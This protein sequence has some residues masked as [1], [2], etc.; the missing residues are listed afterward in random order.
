MSTWQEIRNKSC[1]EI[2]SD[3]ETIEVLYNHDHNGN[4]Y[5]EIPIEFV[6]SLVKERAIM[7]EKKRYEDEIEKLKSIIG[8]CE[9]KHPIREPGYS[10]CETCHQHVSEEKMNELTKE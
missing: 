1:V 6:I 3:G 2:S 4:N 9:C 7:E 5:I 8:K 10:Y